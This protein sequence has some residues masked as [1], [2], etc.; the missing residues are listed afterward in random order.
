MVNGPKN[1]FCTVGPITLNGTE[2]IFGTVACIRHILKVQK[3]FSGPF[4][5]DTDADA[6]F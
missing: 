6:D 4:L 5:T 3:G 2:R 1:P